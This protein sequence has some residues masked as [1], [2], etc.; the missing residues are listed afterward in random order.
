MSTLIE[1]EKFLNAGNL[2]ERFSNVGREIGTQYKEGKAA[3]KGGTIKSATVRNWS[4]ILQR[5]SRR[6]YKTRASNASLLK[7]KGSG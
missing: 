1:N 6:L 2:F 3:G 4:L 5:I 7:V